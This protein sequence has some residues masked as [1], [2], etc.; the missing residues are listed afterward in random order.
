MSTTPKQ[1]T[2][3]QRFTRITVYTHD[4]H[5]LHRKFL[6]VFPYSPKRSAPDR[7]YIFNVDDI[8]ARLKKCLDWS[9]DNTSIHQKVVVSIVQALHDEFI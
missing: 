5:I 9:L 6:R 8:E 4:G 3:Y 1:R 2:T 7:P